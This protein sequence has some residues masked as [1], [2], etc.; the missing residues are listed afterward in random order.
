VSVGSAQLQR[1]IT[2][3]APGT[4]ATDAV[5]VQQLNQSMTQAYTFAAQGT[6]QALAVPSIPT[7]A[8][9]HKWI[10]MAAGSFAGQAAVGMA[11]GYQITEHWNAGGGV[12]AS[13]TGG[14][15]VAAKAQIGF[16]F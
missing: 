11:L 8:P 5:N 3:V 14:S 13:T 1:Q 15:H 2:N 6:A 9:G 12:S 7:L 10:G 16:E 4:Q